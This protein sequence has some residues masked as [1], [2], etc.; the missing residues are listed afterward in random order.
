MQAL[1]LI[2]IGIVAGLNS[3]SA[4]MRLAP[5]YTG[6]NSTEVRMMFQ[7]FVEFSSPQRPDA[8]LA[9]RKIDKQV[10]H[11]Y[12]TMWVAARRGGIKDDYVIEDIRI[13][14]KEGANSVW[15]ATYS[16]RG[17]A[18]LE[19]GHSTEYRITM[20]INPDEV[21]EASKV[22]SN[23][24]VYHPCVSS[25]GRTEGEFYYYW[26]PRLRYCP[27]REGLH[28]LNLTAAVEPIPNTHLTY[29]E[30]E[31]LLDDSGTLQ[32][33]LLMGMHEEGNSWDPLTS[34]DPNARNYRNIRYSLQ[35]MGYEFRRW[36]RSETALFLGMSEDSTDL[37]YVEEIWKD[38]VRGR[39]RI[40]AFFGAS[41]LDGGRAKA[42]HHFL[43]DSLENFSIMVYGGHSGYGANY[44]LKR[45]EQLYGW[46][47]QPAVDRYQIYY[48]NSCSSYAAYN[49]EFFSRK[50]TE[51]D[52]KGRKNLEVLTT[53]LATRFSDIDGG[54]IALLRVLDQ[55]IEKRGAPSYQEIV[56]RLE[57]N[58]LV[59]VNGDEDNPTVPPGAN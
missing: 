48:I 45:I 22:V 57:H 41:S 14:P 5:L 37:P 53:G 26:N 7:H 28:Y 16:Y 58:N 40:R 49:R 44:D 19:R 29:P 3:S 24:T 56:R 12:G 46:T 25:G 47:L 10:A 51:A 11:L 54:N 55:W 30:Y 36:S 8:D 23:G 18:V 38:S 35:R 6:Y 33:S 21:Y 15:R 9:M 27:L 39:M 31:L 32:V 50:K 13:S 20:P 17:T 52:P 42:F 34:S 1:L 43:K 59:G 2:S 4:D